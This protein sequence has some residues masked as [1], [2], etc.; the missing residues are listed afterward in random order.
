MVTGPMVH[1]VGYNRVNVLSSRFAPYRIRGCGV[2]AGTGGAGGLRLQANA[3]DSLNNRNSFLAHTQSNRYLAES[4]VLQKGGRY[5]RNTVV[6]IH[7]HSDAR[8]VVTD[9]TAEPR[10]LAIGDADRGGSRGVR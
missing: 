3:P 6:M 1:R 4:Q 8:T 9:E 7:G 2:A 5:C 10:R